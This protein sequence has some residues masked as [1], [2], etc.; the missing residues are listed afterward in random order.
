[1]DRSVGTT[2]P[3]G[4]TMEIAQKD[5]HVSPLRA[6]L[7]ALATEFGFGILAAVRQTSL[8][9]LLGGRLAGAYDREP[10]GRANAIQGD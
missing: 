3:A 10:V 9:E 6:R 4:G 5:I 8:A 2:T 7:V 1:M